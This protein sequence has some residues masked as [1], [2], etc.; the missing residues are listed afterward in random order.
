MCLKGPSLTLLTS[1]QFWCEAPT[2]ER[3]VGNSMINH[4]PSGLT[5]DQNA[6]LLT[7]KSA[8][9]ASLLGDL[10]QRALLCALRA[11]W[12]YDKS[13][14]QGRQKHICCFERALCSNLETAW[15]P[16]DHN[17]LFFVLWRAAAA[18]TAEV[19]WSGSTTGVELQMWVAVAAENLLCSPGLQGR[20]PFFCLQPSC[21]GQHLGDLG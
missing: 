9:I 5:M 17:Q 6:H 7:L 11:V 10:A 21:L 3:L 14:L 8:A 1:C 16:N 4:P 2:F 13:D 18:Q 12:Q 19:H 15:C 20:A